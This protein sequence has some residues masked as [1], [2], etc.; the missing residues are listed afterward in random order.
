MKRSLRVLVLLILAGCLMT[1]TAFADMGPKPQLTVKV[2]H[3]PQEL[4]W[5]DLLAEGDPNERYPLPEDDF[6]FGTN[7]KELGF[8]DAERY[9]AMNDAVPDGWHACI[10]QHSGPPIW[11]SLTG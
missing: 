6:H 4:Y 11:G 2:E 10:T 8:P 3:P 7:L 5:L 9:Y 1:I